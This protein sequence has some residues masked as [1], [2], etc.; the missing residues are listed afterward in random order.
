MHEHVV[1]SKLL[2]QAH[3][4]MQLSQGWAGSSARTRGFKHILARIK[5]WDATVSGMGGVECTNAWFQKHCCVYQALECNCLRDEW[6][7]V[8][9][10]VVSN[11][12]W[13]VSSFG[14]HLS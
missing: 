9:E 7:R 12:F 1:L 10:R 2:L 5:F 14:M 8:H 3:F 11:T 13:R 6:G 4:E